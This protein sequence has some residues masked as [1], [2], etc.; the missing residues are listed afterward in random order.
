M[1]SRADLLALQVRQ[2]KQKKKN[3]KKATLYLR[4]E[5]K[6]NKKLF[7]ERHQTNNSFNVSNLVLLHNI[8]LDNHYDMKLT[9]Q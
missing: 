6:E 5:K 9:S 4:H 8:K 2:L 1:R 3:V 7:N